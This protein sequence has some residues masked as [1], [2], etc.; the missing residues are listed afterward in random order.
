MQE[1]HPHVLLNVFLNPDYLRLV[2]TFSEESAKTF[3]LSDVEALKLTL[4][5]EELFIYLCRTSRT[6]EGI[7]I[8]ATNGGYYVQVKFLFNVQKFNPRAFNLT[9]TVSPEDTASLDEMGLLLASR[10]VDRF[11][12][13]GNS[14]EGLELMLIKEKSYPAHAGLKTPE[15]KGSNRY[16]IQIPDTESLKLFCRMAIAL[17]PDNL[18]PPA[19]SF[20]GKVVDMILSE[21]YGASVAMGDQGQLGG[22]IFWHW[23][24]TKTVESFGPYVFNQPDGSE[25][26]LRLVDSCIE[27]IAKTDALGLIHRYATPDLPGGYL[28]QLGS[29]DVMQPDGKTHP[30]PIYY[31]HLH[32]DLG[33]RVFAHPDLEAFLRGEYKR[34]FLARE[35]HLTRNEGE[36]RPSHSV[37]APGFDRSNGQ[38]TLKAIWDGVDAAENLAQHLKVFTAEN[39]QNIFF[40]IDLASAWQANLTPALLENRFQPRLILP[41]AG[42]A[43]VVVFQYQ[44]GG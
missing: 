32:E 43:D 26:A 36:Q 31:R 28:E 44:K 15:I 3:G 21:E 22:G 41:Y 9:S 30:R 25:L 29:I 40:E 19:F 1:R 8:E 7:A 10:Q 27:K 37:F 18:C 38:I 13:A 14:Q 35:I 20:P 33:C 6:E 12:I 11:S 17:Y 24:G 2:T 16:A 34:L 39:L 42:E 5:C 4:A 23:V